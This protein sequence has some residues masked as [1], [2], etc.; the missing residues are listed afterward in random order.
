MSELSGGKAE[1]LTED[2]ARQPCGKYHKIILDVLNYNLSQFSKEVAVVDCVID[3]DNTFLV[4]GGVIPI[5]VDFAGV[6]LA[7][8]HSKSE[9][10]TKLATLEE[11]YL[12]PVI[13]GEDRKIVV[14]A[15]I[16]SIIGRKI[17]VD[18]IVENEKREL[19]GTAQLLF[20]ERKEPA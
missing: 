8:M 19:K 4:Q 10:I 20:I 13:L 9:F 18:V 12:K 14:R 6:Y 17:L 5:I 3:Q 16:N 7:R 15:L 1:Q 11:K 2:Y